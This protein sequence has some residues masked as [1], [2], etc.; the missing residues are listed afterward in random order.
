MI[1]SLTCILKN[2]GSRHDIIMTT[3]TPLLVSCCLL[4]IPSYFMIA[5]LSGQVT[6]T[7]DRIKCTHMLITSL[8]AC[9]MQ[10]VTSF[11]SNERACQKMHTMVKRQVQQQGVCL[12]VQQQR[13]PLS[14]AASP[15]DR[16]LTGGRTGEVVITAGLDAAGKGLAPAGSSPGAQTAPD[17]RI[18]PSRHQPQ[19]QV[20]PATLLCQ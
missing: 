16:L 15:D 19:A 11:L 10:C 13:Q 18:D 20:S 4:A 17:Q 14:S 6:A 2:A 7:I 12:Q 8:A 3:I 5:L 1:C 9:L